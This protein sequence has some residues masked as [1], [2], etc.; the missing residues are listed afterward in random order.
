MQCTMKGGMGPLVAGS[1]D[2]TSASASHSICYLHRLVSTQQLE[3]VERQDRSADL[4]IVT[5]AINGTFATITTPIPITN[6]S[7]KKDKTDLWIS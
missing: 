5:I 4:L 1:L 6:L 2:R 7:P 3:L